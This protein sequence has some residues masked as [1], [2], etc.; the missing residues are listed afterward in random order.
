[1]TRVERIE[2]TCTENGS[3]EYYLCSGCN[4]K[5]SDENATAELTDVIIFA[6][7]TG[8]TEIR[9]AKPAGEY[10]DGY[11]GDTYCLGCE[12]LISYGTVLPHT[13]DAPTIVVTDAVIEDNTLRAVISI[14]NNPGIVSL[15]FDILYSEAL[16]I[17]SIEFSD[18]FGAYVTAP[19]PYIN[20]Q[21]V[22]WISMGENLLINGEFITVTFSVDSEA[23]V[24]EA[25][26]IRIIAD[27]ENIFDSET[28]PVSFNTV[29]ITL[30]VSE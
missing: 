29:G 1:M 12:N 19:E 11:S 26:E 25:F 14:V 22:N 5:F 20:P 7:H 6:A 24:S 3:I 8:E 15:K 27:S 16:S 2:A 23:A 4:K 17:L 13:S 10:T 28:N 21:T 18:E 9:N 30:T